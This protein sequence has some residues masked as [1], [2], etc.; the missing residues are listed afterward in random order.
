MRIPGH[1]PFDC[2]AIRSLAGREASVGAKGEKSCPER[3]IRLPIQHFRRAFTLLELLIVIAIILILAGLLLPAVMI[4]R[5]HATKAAALT[6]TKNIEAAWTRYY[7]EY[8]KWPGF[9]DENSAVAITG[10]VARI[11]LGLG[12][13]DNPKG[14][15]FIQ[16]SRFD[17]LTNP[18]SP[19]GRTRT[20]ATNCWYYC[21]FDTD[22]DHLIRA[23][24]N[25][26]PSADVIKPVIVWTVSRDATNEIVGSWMK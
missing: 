3:K 16:F 9:A 10:D 20:S 14:L 13:N 25:G 5:R 26:Q 17:V 19:W 4:A 6:E 1:K 12:T 21:K 23:T 7:A 11:L 8:Q 24:G 2:A 22:F 15:A 18:V